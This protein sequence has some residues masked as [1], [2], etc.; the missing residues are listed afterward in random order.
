MT[1]D[2]Q[3]RFFFLLL[4]FFTK[5]A[6]TTLS[7]FS[8]FTCSSKKSNNLKH[9]FHFWRAF[10]WAELSM[11]K[12]LYFYL[13]C[14]TLHKIVSFLVAFYRKQALELLRLNDLAYF[15]DCVSRNSFYWLFGSLFCKVCCASLYF[16]YH[17]KQIRK[18]SSN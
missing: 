3:N 8:R 7:F 4:R 2:H 5:I 13:C 9:F 18:H 6:T 15:N 11:R 12:F 14:F 16:V 1:L 17:S 10:L